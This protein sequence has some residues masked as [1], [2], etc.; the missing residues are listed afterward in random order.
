MMDEDQSLKQN[1]KEL[2]LLLLYLNSWI[3]KEW[4]FDYRRS[5]KGYDFGVL[6]ELSDEGVITDSR[7]SKSVGITEAGEKKAKELMG[8]YLVEC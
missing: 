1:I 7:R 6:N 5:W 8:K 4:D 2:T 3:E